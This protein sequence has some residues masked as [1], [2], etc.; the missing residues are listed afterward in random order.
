MKMKKSIVAIVAFS[1]FLVVP[2]KA[3]VIYSFLSKAATFDDL[4]TANV[5]LTDG[6]TQFI[7]TVSSV[8][9]NLNSNASG[10]G[11]GDANIDGTGESITLSFDFDVEFNFIDLGGTGTAMEAESDGASFTINGNTINL[12][13]GQPNYNGSTGVYTP[14]SPIA[15]T[16]GNA[17]VLTGSSITS[18]FDLDGINVSAVPEPTTALLSALGALALLRR[19]RR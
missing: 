17:I 4:T 11:V 12:F 8:G 7:M 3:A 13:T 9:G 2:S 15:L 10:L 19:R 14:S 6:S 1:A 5:S 18:I 16:A